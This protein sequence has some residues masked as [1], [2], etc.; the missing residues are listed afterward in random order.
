MHGRS[1]THTAIV[2]LVMLWSSTASAQS[3]KS[4]SFQVEH[5]EPLP[6]QGPNLGNL[7]GS[8]PLDA[9]RPSLGLT[10]HY[11]DDPLQ[12]RENGDEANRVIGSQVK[13]ELGFAYGILGF[14]DIGVVL[15]IV[16][17]QSLGDLED[18][19]VDGEPPG[20]TVADLRIV[21]KFRF[22]DA[23][24][25]GG[26]GASALLVTYLPTGNTNTFNGDGTV[27]VEPRLA[28][29]WTHELG[30]RVIA[31]L[32]LQLR[33]ER[34][35]LTYVSDDL[36]RFGLGA[37]YALPIDGMST[38]ASLFGQRTLAKGRDATNLDEP[39]PNAEAFPLEAQ[40][41]L[42]SALP[43]NLLAHVGAGFG[44]TPSVG[45]PDFRVV[46]GLE[47]TPV[48][49][50]DT[51]GDGLKDSADECVDEAEDRDGF[52]DQDGCPDFDNDGDR[53]LDDVDQCPSEAEDEDGFED[54]DGCPEADNDND[55]LVD[56]DDRC[57]DQPG[58]AA[59]MGCPEE[60]TDGDG[61]SD[62]LEQCPEVA[63]DFDGFED[64]DGCPD[65]DNDGDGIPD[66]ADACPDQP[67]VVNE[68]DDTD[69]CPDP[70]ES[71]VALSDRRVRLT[72]PVEFASRTRLT[73]ASRTVLN[74][75]AAL[76]ANHPEVTRIRIE[77]HTDDRGDDD[78]NLALS[79]R[80]AESVLKHLTDAGVSPNRLV[81]VGRGE[82]APDEIGDVRARVELHR[83]SEN[84]GESEPA[85]DGEPGFDFTGGAGAN[86]KQPAA[87]TD[88]DPA[89]APP[90]DVEPDGFQFGEEE[91]Q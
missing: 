55:G 22:L 1:I 32:G 26:F 75:V 10:L 83:V 2:S 85:P 18:F 89:D 47:W 63:E 91:V 13:A 20:T 44:L 5:F 31:N 88:D 39:A 40:L 38:S 43:A 80:Q 46:A 4:T 19:G 24:G 70:G 60:D 57:P 65:R 62:H 33:G 56:H 77:V 16:L 76:L 15:P 51:D 86:T 68:N 42:R 29:D 78:A 71:H 81:A 59:N 35:A 12:V 17:S 66:A 6:A 21:P 67:E 72:R 30:L 37:E 53:V 7:A 90:D 79:Q 45:S 50:K 8:A 41:G 3:A 23:A 14:A 82:S 48:L 34:A 54:E 25:T 69:G 27:R 11:V 52:E 84:H 9:N 61:L 28:A 49:R 74:Q 73:R 58:P 36:L 87:P 64:E